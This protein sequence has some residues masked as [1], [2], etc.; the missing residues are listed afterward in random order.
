MIDIEWM[1]KWTASHNEYFSHLEHVADLPQVP[2]CITHSLLHCTEHH[3]FCS[4]AAG[5]CAAV[6]RDRPTEPLQQGD[7]TTLA[8]PRGDRLS[9]M[10]E[11]MF[12]TEVCLITEKITS[13]RD[14]ETK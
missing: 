2:C 12:E 14:A 7:E 13:I 5:V 6:T 3:V 10:L 11:Q 4:H 9:P 8:L 1:K